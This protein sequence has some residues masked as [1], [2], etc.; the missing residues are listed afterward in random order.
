MDTRRHA[1]TVKCGF[2]L[3]WFLA[4]QVF[5]QTRSAALQEFG[6]E[7]F[8]WRARTQPCSGDD[9]PRIE[10][11]KGWVPS[12]SGDSLQAMRERYAD[13]RR[14]LDAIEQEGWS[15]SDSVDYLLLRSAVERVRW[16]LDKLRAPSRDPGFYVQQT[17][18]AVFE[19][20]LPQ[21]AMTR[22][23]A[24][25]IILRLRS[26]P[27]TLRAA[28]ENL[29]EPVRP[30][31]AGALHGLEG[32]RKR[33]QTMVEGLKPVVPRDLHAPLADAASAGDSLEAFASWLEEGLPAMSDDAG[34]GRG[35][36]EYFLRTIALNPMTTDRMLA[37][38]QSEFDRAAAFEGM[39][40]LRNA[41]LPEPGLFKS[42]D[43]QI[44]QQKTD[45]AAIRKFLTDRRLLT[46]PAWVKHYTV[47]PRPPYL[48]TM[49]GMGV[50]DDLTSAT[51]LTENGVSY[52]PPPSADLSYF[53]RATAQDPR[54]ITLHEGVPGHYFQLVMSWNNPDPL[55]RHYFDSG[56]N[57]GWAFYVEEMMLQAG[58]FDTDRARA[59]ETI[60]NFMRLR[61]LRVA[62][63]IK[64]ALGDFTIDE[65]AAF[66]ASMVPM[67]RP[68]AAGE[69]AF[70]ASTPGQGISYQIGKLQILKFISDARTVQGKAFDLR[71]VHDY[72]ALNGNVPIAL[73]RW[74]YLGLRDEIEELW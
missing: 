47:G 43:Q 59:R 65:A 20:L 32:V 61:A 22:D 3:A 17:L 6:D 33:L 35:A 55:R 64:L 44:G 63:D 1:L 25:E 49:A 39:E 4:A 13:F 12:F 36:Y 18:G 16:E 67:D 7:F 2:L 45:E 73:L 37:L 62:S 66:L 68:T 8:S 58:L 26:I 15:R 29:T 9:I 30:F 41:R 24:E 42:L 57:E 27:G 28:R 74:E 48:A 46:I 5:G 31:S 52:I 40:R 72:I 71:A 53:Y 19:L 23:R 60:Y 14:R 51:R 10:R 21:G 69:A 54:P 38:G 34:V 56:A 70:F 11:P 50:T